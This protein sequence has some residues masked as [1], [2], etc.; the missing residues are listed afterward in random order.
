M[1]LLLA[2]PDPTTVDGPASLSAIALTPRGA[3]VRF[4]A[5][6]HVSDQVQM[7]LELDTTQFQDK[8]LVFGVSLAHPIQ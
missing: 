3:S 8:V 6:H 1:S 4:E 5:S 2:L 7:E